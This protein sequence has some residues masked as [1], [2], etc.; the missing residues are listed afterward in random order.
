M[1]HQRGLDRSQTLLF[2]ERLEDYIAA[3]NTVR[4]LDAFVASL[5]LHTLSFAK[6]RCAD[7]GRPPYDPAALLKLYLYGYLHR[8]R[9]SRLLEAECRRNVEVIWLLGKLA[10]DFKTIADF[11]KDNLKPL[12]AVNRQFTVLCRKLELFGGELL[13][14]DGSK[15]GAVNARDQNFNAAR[16][17]D[18]IGR[19]DARLGE[20]LKELDSADAA[21]P[22]SAAMNKMELAAKIAA[23]QE[24]QEWH[25]ELLAQLDEEQKQI[26]VTDPDTRKMPTAQGMMVGYNAQM[27]VD[28]KHKLIAA[29]DV[30]NE[31]TDF[32]QL[33]NVALEARANLELKQ[34]DVVADA[35][36]YNAAEVSRCVEAGLTPLIPKADTSA[37]TARGLYG[38]SR[39][40]YDET[41]DV[42][43]CPAGAELTHRFNT[44]ELG[45]ELRYYR[46]SGCKGCA[47]KKQCTRN[48]ANRTITRE[49]NE[50]LMEAMAARMKAQPWKFKLRKTLAEHPF[51]TIKRWFGYTHFL[52]K[53]LEKVRCEWSLT[54]LAYNLKRVLNLVSFEKLMSILRRIASE[55]RAAVGVK[56][57]QRA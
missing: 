3:E 7:T 22:A 19:A 23:L 48:K 43:V 24:K 34:A 54:T 25:K 51:G 33:A 31:V 12:R 50:G 2:P 41:K 20:Y 29:D 27:A 16:L 32:K 26:S 38:K 45:R 39:F 21:E 49:E 44:Y 55:D 35:G 11:R 4:F 42:Y 56:V 13:A 30:T 10:P 18:L 14:I 37:N 9:S 28:A 47:M 15:F 17:E 52:L 46:A 57:P 8:I 5:D 36:Y 40:R 1:N 53:G 6:A